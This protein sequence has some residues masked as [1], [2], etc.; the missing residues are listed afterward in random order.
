MAEA[1][2][3][4]STKEK[5]A[6]DDAANIVGRLTGDTAT[7]ITDPKFFERILATLASVSS[8]RERGSLLQRT[9]MVVADILKSQPQFEKA[10]KDLNDF[11]NR[12]GQLLAGA[13]P[14]NKKNLEMAR[15]II[16][17][18]IVETYLGALEEEGTVQGRTDY[19]KKSKQVILELIGVDKIE[20]VALDK[21]QTKLLKFI[22]DPEARDDLV[23]RTAFATVDILKGIALDSKDKELFSRAADLLLAVKNQ[24]VPSSED[25]YRLQ[26]SLAEAYLG[27]E[28]YQQAIEAIMALRLKPKQNISSP[29]PM[30]IPF[31]EDH[32]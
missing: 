30:Y 31:G 21:L 27:A 18:S 2:V 19:L 13:S 24:V 16:Q 29:F 7:S 12:A 5:S 25:F 26:V 1:L 32:A 9:A 10:E 22:N 28:S 17:L 11:F 20:D 8:R 4:K 15:H 3:Q 6:R 23:K 14:E